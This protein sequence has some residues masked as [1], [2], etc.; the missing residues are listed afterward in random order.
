MVSE[1]PFQIPGVEDEDLATVARRVP[2][3]PNTRAAGADRFA[4][5][6]RTLVERRAQANWPDEGP[7]DLAVFVLVDYPRRVGEAHGGT[8]FA[9]LMAQGTPLLG[10]VFFSNADASRGQWV[11]MPAPANA[12]PDWLEDEGLGNCPVVTVYRGTKEMAIRRD[13][14]GDSATYDAIRD[15]EPTASLAELNAALGLFHKRRVLTP[16]CPGVW[17]DGRAAQ[18]VPGPQP[19]R[20]IQA[21]LEIALN[22]WFRGVVRAECEDSTDIGRIDVRLLKKSAE[23][24]LAYWVILELKVIKSF[25]NAAIGVNPSKVSDG[26]NVE[27]IVKGVQQA[28]AYRA[29]REAEEGMLEVY[30][31]R[32]D[33]SE[34][35][36]ERVEVSTAKGMYRPPP[37]IHVWQAFG[38]DSDAR[39]AGYTG[40]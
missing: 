37:R 7:E 16:A 2:E 11:A 14:V 31:L 6:V 36:T 34:D 5:S 35:L 28:G 25:T 30:D 3:L 12:M 24:G 10:R 13:G 8:P 19:E 22:F 32:R 27:A 33:K 17:E 21:D 29:N 15:T 4:Q 20:S 9:D 38:T 26:T 18:Y 40:A 23:L 1:S 39:A